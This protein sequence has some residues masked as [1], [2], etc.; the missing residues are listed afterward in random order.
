MIRF[1]YVLLS[2][3]ITVMGSAW[4]A[5]ITENQAREIATSFMATHSMPSA[6]LKMA[7]RAPLMSAAMKPGIRHCRWR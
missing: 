6:S 7:H 5:S 4:G 2:V 1:R 3:F